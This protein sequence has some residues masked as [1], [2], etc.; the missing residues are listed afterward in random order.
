M[1][2]KDPPTVRNRKMTLIEMLGRNLTTAFSI[3]KVML[4]LHVSQLTVISGQ[5]ETSK[6]LIFG[7]FHHK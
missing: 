4:R 2:C 1:A 5:A 6:I 3:P 7:V